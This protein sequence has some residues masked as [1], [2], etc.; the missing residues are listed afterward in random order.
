VVFGFG[1]RKDFCVFGLDQ[2][3]L[4]RKQQ[5]PQNCPR[6]EFQK[7]AT[8]YSGLWQQP[9]KITTLFHKTTTQ[10]TSFERGFYFA[11]AFAVRFSTNR[12]SEINVVGG[13]F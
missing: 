6:K 8:R 1:I 11:A 7:V 5:N 10:M 12:M 3:Q 2:E 13:L 4:L 9:A